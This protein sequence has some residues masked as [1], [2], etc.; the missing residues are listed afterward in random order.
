MLTY[1]IIQYIFIVILLNDWLKFLRLPCKLLRMPT[2]IFETFT[3]LTFWVGGF[4]ESVVY[5]SVV[6]ISPCR[7]YL[8]LKFT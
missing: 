6:V 2:T 7:N 5:E 4:L 3:S 1:L 8:S